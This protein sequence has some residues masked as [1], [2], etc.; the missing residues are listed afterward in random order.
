MECGRVGHR[1]VHFWIC[2]GSDNIQVCLL[3]MLRWRSQGKRKQKFVTLG[4]SRIPLFPKQNFLKLTGGKWLPCVEWKGNKPD[5]HELQV[6]ENLHG[7]D[8]LCLWCNGDKVDILINVPCISEGVEYA[9]DN[10]SSQS[11][12]ERSYDQWDMVQA[13]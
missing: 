6:Q 4:I 3:V 7:P 11:E 10:S 1:A 13:I 12:K 9:A 5:V 8:C 2:K